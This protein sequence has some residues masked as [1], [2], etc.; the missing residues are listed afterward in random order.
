MSPLTLLPFHC[1]ILFFVAFCECHWFTKTQWSWV[2]SLSGSTNV[3]ASGSWIVLCSGWLKTCPQQRLCLQMYHCCYN[4]N[5]IMLDKLLLLRVVWKDL[6]AIFLWTGKMLHMR[7]EWFAHL[8]VS[9]GMGIESVRCSRG[10]EC[11]FNGVRLDVC[12]SLLLLKMC[13]HLRNL[14]TGWCSVAMN[15]WQRV[16]VE[17]SAWSSDELERCVKSGATNLPECLLSPAVFGQDAK[18]TWSGAF[19][20][21]CL[22]VMEQKGTKDKVQRQLFCCCS[23]L[24]V[25]DR[26]YVRQGH[27]LWMACCPASCLHSVASVAVHSQDFSSSTTPQTACLP[28]TLSVDSGASCNT[29]PST[30]SAWWIVT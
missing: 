5:Q 4:G 19:L 6:C 26:V 24:K 15:E 18:G 7:E 25:I 22:F 1:E 2:Y 21:Y 17:L 13:A 23:M 3:R 30:L 20:E 14:Q 29:A 16:R 9:C 8:G 27:E 11:C 28:R 12:E 10:C